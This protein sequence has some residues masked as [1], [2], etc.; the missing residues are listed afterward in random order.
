MESAFQTR[1]KLDLFSLRMEIPFRFILNFSECR[2]TTEIHSVLFSMKKSLKVPKNTVFNHLKVV[3]KGSP[4]SLDIH[5]LSECHHLYDLSR[6][7][8]Q[9]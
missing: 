3:L 9:P 5:D 8:G 6:H 1:S 4:R 2:Y 7:A